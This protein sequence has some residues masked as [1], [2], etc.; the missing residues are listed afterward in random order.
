[1]AD[2]PEWA[3]D[4]VFYQVFP[5]RFAASDRVEKPGA[6]E[7][8][9]A[10]PTHWGY[11]GGDL[12]GACRASRRAGRP[13]DH[14][15]LPEPDLLGG[16]EPSIQRLRLSVGGSAAWRR[17]RT[18]GAARRGA[19]TGHPGRA[20][21]RLQP[22]GSGVLAVPSPA[23]EWRRLAVSRLV[24]PDARVLAGRRGLHAYDVPRGVSAQSRGYRSWWD[25]PALPKLRVEHPPVRAH[26][27]EVAEHWLRFGIDGWRLDVPRMS[28]TRRS[29]RNSGGASGQ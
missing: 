19:S 18:A 26:L 5:D 2:A 1:M 10:P 22:R 13:G 17:R 28:R 8:W 4:A 20:R 6:L 23:R 25:V 15:A 21:W 29:G 12:F 3:R 7:P 27:F 9:D 11:K 16:L 24:L 14:G